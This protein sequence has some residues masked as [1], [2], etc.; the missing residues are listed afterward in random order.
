MTAAT[1]P[2][3]KDALVAR[4]RARQA[5]V[6]VIGLGYV[7]LPLAV[8][9]AEAGFAVVGLDVAEARVEA[10]NAGESPV[11]DLPGERLAGLL[12]ADRF[13][14]T[15]DRAVLA[16]ADACVICV[17]T[18]L[19]KTKEPDISYVVSATEA[20]REHLRRGQLVILES[21]TYPGTTDELIRG[22]LEETGL[23]ADEDFFLAFSP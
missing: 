19:R 1:E 8:E 14:A 4:F 12:E 2:S 21:T 18:P 23:R 9:L 13:R 3:T 16:T 5:R 15:T 6:A 11:L 7:G 17:P 20:I 10:V 22:M